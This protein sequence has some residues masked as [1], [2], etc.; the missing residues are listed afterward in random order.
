MQ[1]VCL[2]MRAYLGIHMYAV[3]CTADAIQNPRGWKL[4][5]SNPMASSNHDFI[6]PADAMILN[7]A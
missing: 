5:V 2:C 4:Q 1:E 6:Y 3:C 7:F